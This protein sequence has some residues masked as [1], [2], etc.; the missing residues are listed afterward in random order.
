MCDVGKVNKMVDSVFTPIL[1]EL[2]DEGMIY[3]FGQFQCIA[4]A[5]NGM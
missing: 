5:M 1:K 2:V 3:S 4:G